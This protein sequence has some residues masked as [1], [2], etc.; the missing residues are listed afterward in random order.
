MRSESE[1]LAAA[2]HEVGHAVV[3]HSVGVAFKSISIEFSVEENTGGNIDCQALGD[4]RDRVESPSRLNSQEQ[5]DAKKLIVM[6]H[7]GV[8]A[9][10]KMT[11]FWNGAGFSGDWQDIYSFLRAITAETSTKQKE[12]KEIDL[13]SRKKSLEIIESK[14]QEI[15][16]L[17]K[18]LCA[19]EFMTAKAVES[20]LDAVRSGSTGVENVR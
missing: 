2:Y 9:E 8:L 4:M 15:E 17:A 13:K 5:D 14:W 3:C 12:M 16:G 18:E 6:L 10:Q 11:G 1:T 19:R 20:L 7:A